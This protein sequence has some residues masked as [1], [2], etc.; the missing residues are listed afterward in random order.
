MQN[1]SVEELAYEL[2]V[3]RGC[4]EGS[5]AEDWHEAERQL[6]LKSHNVTVESHAVQSHEV[7][8]HEVQ[9]REAEIDEGLKE[10]FPASDPPASHLPDEPPDNAAEVRQKPSKSRKPSARTTAQPRAPRP[11]PDASK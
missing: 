5:S 4:P 8:S 6:T 9:S 2:W 10:S 3:A 11:R 1:K 7:P